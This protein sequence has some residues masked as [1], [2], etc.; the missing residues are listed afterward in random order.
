[1]EHGEMRLAYNADNRAWEALPEPYAVLEI[2]TEEA[3]NKL[4][5]MIAFY[6]KYHPDEDISPFDSMP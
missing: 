3:Y 6:G 4:C 2:A 5:K 1:M